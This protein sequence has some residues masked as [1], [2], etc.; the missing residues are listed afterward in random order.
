L[1]ADSR[2]MEPPPSLLHNARVL[3]YAIFD[4]TVRRT[5]SWL[6]DAFKGVGLRTNPGVAQVEEVECREIARERNR[7][8]FPRSP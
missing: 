2:M 4:P 5:E 1:S 3:E 8:I 7:A 6:I